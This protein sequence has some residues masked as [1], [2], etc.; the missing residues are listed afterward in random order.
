GISGWTGTETAEEEEHESTRI[1]TNLHESDSNEIRED[2]CEFVLIRVPLRHNGCLL[3][4]NLTPSRT[5]ATIARYVRAP[6]R[7]CRRANEAH[8]PSPSEDMRDT[9]LT[10]REQRLAWRRRLRHGCSR[11]PTRGSPSSW[12]CAVS[13][14]TSAFS[15]ARRSLTSSNST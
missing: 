3:S 8:P 15:S 7:T 14:G 12:S 6:L 4:P 1:G 10:A 5:V 11:P 2:S 13:R 9:H